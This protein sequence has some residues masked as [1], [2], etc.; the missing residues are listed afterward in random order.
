MMF[1]GKINVWRCFGWKGLEE[2]FEIQ[3]NLD[4][5]QYCDILRDNLY[6]SAH[7]MGYGNNFIFQQDNDPKHTSRLA[8]DFFVSNEIKK[9]NHP[10][11]SA[12][13][14]PIEH[15]WDK[16]DRRITDRYRISI[17]IYKRRLFEV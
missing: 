12:D 10:R 15:L 14:N 16:A 5:K 1:P 8:T 6:L 4:A 2:L 13:L 11:Q 17:N 9:L 7:Y 3:G